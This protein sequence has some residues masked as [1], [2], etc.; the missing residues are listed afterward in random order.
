MEYETEHVL[1]LSKW[2]LGFGR[3]LMRYCAVV[4][5]VCAAVMVSAA[6]ESIGEALEGDASSDTVSQLIQQLNF[7]EYPNVAAAAER[8]IEEIEATS[9]RY[10]MALALPLTLLG[11]AQ[12]G[13]G[14]GDGA[15]LAYERA[16]HVTRVSDGLFT[17]AQVV[18]VYRQALVHATQGDHI[19]ANNRHEYAYGVL[20]RAYGADS[21]DLLPGLFRLANWYRSTGNLLAA[22]GSYQHAVELAKAHRE[23]GD[24][25]TIEALRGVAATLRDARFPT[26][27]RRQTNAAVIAAPLGYRPARPLSNQIS[28]FA[29][30]EHALQ[31]V[32]NLK[33]A[34]PHAT[35]L[36]LAEAVLELADWL[37]LFEKHGRAMPLY[38]RVWGLMEEDP[39]LRDATF[40]VPTPLF[41]PLARAPNPPSAANPGKPQDGIVE[42]SMTITR[43]GLVSRIHTVRSEPKGMMDFK[44][45]KATRLARYRPA[46]AKTTP[47]RTEDVRVKYE[48]K[49]YPD[50]ARNHHVPEASSPSQSP[51]PRTQS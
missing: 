30:G 41:L 16:L 17:P 13:M 22:L 39:A 46:F 34:D 10:D 43:R 2:F 48:F 20:L 11:D 36:E 25:V 24:S 29:P 7:G 12:L 14:D 15:L 40:Q 49:Y 32:V 44:V 45:R 42:L 33:Q 6:Q 9:T 19:A 26:Y 38:A 31:E 8:M 4:T 3:A 28:P 18:I 47:L 51:E 50:S 1:S 35:R 37:L 21:P 5:F 27:G 23:L